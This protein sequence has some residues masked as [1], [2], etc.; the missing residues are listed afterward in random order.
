MNIAFYL[1]SLA[2]DNKIALIQKELLANKEYISNASIFFNGIA[3]LKHDVSAGIFHVCD[4]WAFE[5]ILIVDTIQNLTKA[6][7]IVNKFKC[8]YYYNANNGDNFANIINHVHLADRVIADGQNMSDNYLRITNTQ[9]DN[10]VEQ[11]N[12]ISRLPL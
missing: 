8:W 12:G 9:V 3:P 6:K 7:N 4:M 5:G 11:Y 1:N 10:I 2:E